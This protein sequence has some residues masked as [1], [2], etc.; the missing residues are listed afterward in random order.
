MKRMS[1]ATLVGVLG[2]TLGACATVENPTPG[3]P[4]ESYNRTMFKV[5]ES[6]DKAVLRPI[7]KGYEAVT[8]SPVRTCIRN[9]FG[10]LE[11]VW[12]GINSMLQ[13]RG[14]DF[15][16]T[17]GRVL[18]NTTVGLGGCID[19]ATMNGAKKIPNDFGTTLGVWGLSDGAYVVLPVLGS[20][21][22][23]DTV[24]LVGDSLGASASY[25]TPW[26][27]DNV[28]LRN[29]LVGVKAVDSRA[30]LL[31]ADDIASDVAIDKYAFIRDAY[32]QNRQA[33]LRSKLED[34]ITDGT[35]DT[36]Y[37]AEDITES[38]HV[39]PG[40]ERREAYRLKLREKR[41]EKLR[42]FDKFSVPEYEDP[43]E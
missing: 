36:A 31:T 21:S 29:S 32:K 14:L 18:F 6:V 27:I 3:D 30:K 41:H 10:N 11:D 23:R 43:G 39:I 34:E 40:Q 42:S 24:G 28:P 7:A 26:A 37:Q 38:G 4:L 16:N 9:I 17:F 2:L 35:P 22:L 19:V 5:N 12:S 13:G 8:P 1:K 20:S 33:L 15:V 25:T